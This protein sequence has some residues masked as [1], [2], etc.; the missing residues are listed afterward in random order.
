MSLSSE[1]SEATSVCLMMSFRTPLPTLITL[2]MSLGVDGTEWSVKYKQTEICV[3]KGSTVFI[4]GTYTKPA[5]LEVKEEFWVTKDFNGNENKPLYCRP[6]NDSGGVQCYVDEQQHFSLKLIN[7]TKED[8]HDYRFRIITN[9]AN[10]KW[11]GDP[12][13]ISVTGSGQTY[14]ITISSNSSGW[15]YCVAQNEHGMLKSASIDVTLKAGHFYIL[16]VAVG[17][18][19]CGIVLPLSI[20]LFM[21]RESLKRTPASSPVIPMTLPHPALLFMRYCRN[22]TKRIITEKSNLQLY[23]NAVKRHLCL[24]SIALLYRFHCEGHFYIL[25]IVVGVGLR[26]IVVPLNSFTDEEEKFKALRKHH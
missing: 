7:V 16:P 1:G 5:G 9:V 18:G 8:E 12:V 17:V 10:E 4:N 3:L 2:F 23:P 25:P 15:Y 11:L 26:G 19:L 21:K 6:T 24:P 22:I 14:N 20:V 13:K